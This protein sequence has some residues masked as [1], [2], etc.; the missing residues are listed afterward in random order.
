MKLP[1]AP[2]SDQIVALIEQQPSWITDMDDGVRQIIARRLAPAS[3]QI[4]PAW[5]GVENSPD[6]EAP[7]AVRPDR[8]RGVEEVRR[9][10]HALDLVGGEWVRR[11]EAHRMNALRRPA[12]QGESLG[13]RNDDPR[14]YNLALLLQQARRIKHIADSP[15]FFQRRPA[16][17]TSERSMDFFHHILQRD[18]VGRI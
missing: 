9:R 5:T 14:P 6:H 13:R 16:G 15:E 2:L 7:V 17:L 10:T 12:D 3:H 8:Q 11:G 18:F 1:A 4:Q